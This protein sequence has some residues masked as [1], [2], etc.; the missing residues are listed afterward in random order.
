M[1]PHMFTLVWRGVCWDRRVRFV[2]CELLTCRLSIAAHT[3]VRYSP[4]YRLAPLLPALAAPGG[5]LRSTPGD[6]HAR[7]GASSIHYS[8]GTQRVQSHCS[9]KAVWSFSLVTIVERIRARYC[10]NAAVFCRVSRR[11]KLTTTPRTRTSSV[12]RRRG[13]TVAAGKQIGIPYPIS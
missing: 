9:L 13:R 10:S 1:L 4:V 5:E 11:Q 8:H 3:C 7:L 6:V 12:R 2:W